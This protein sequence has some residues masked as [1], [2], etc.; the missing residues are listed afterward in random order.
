MSHWMIV[1]NKTNPANT[2]YL[3]A[4]GSILIQFSLPPANYA[5]EEDQSDGESNLGMSNCLQRFTC[6]DPIF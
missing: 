6:A 4:L 3:A 5:S 1:R 2:G